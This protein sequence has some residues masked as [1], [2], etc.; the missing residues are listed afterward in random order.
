MLRNLGFQPTLLR[1]V[2]GFHPPNPPVGG[3]SL[4]SSPLQPPF[5]GR[6]YLPL[7]PSFLFFLLCVEF[8]VSQPP[9]RGVARH[10]YVVR[11]VICTV[12]RL[13]FGVS[14][15]LTQLAGTTLVYIRRLRL[16]ILH[17]LRP[18]GSMRGAAPP[19]ISRFAREFPAGI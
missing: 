17:K 8:D 9:T 19:L 11:P 3:I 2:G 15:P 18:G 10:E 5:R 7:T 12:A 1:N 14:L 6:Y 4:R 16:L 13:L